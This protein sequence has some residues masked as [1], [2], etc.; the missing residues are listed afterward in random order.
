VWWVRYCIG[1]ASGSSWM[2]SETDE[3][4]VV[5]E[6]IDVRPIRT[7]AILCLSTVAKY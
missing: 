5:G 2:E 6:L 7:I 1:R 3:I 4:V